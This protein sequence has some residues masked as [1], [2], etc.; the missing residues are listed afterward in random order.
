MRVKNQVICIKT[1][2]PFYHG[3]SQLTSVKV[4]GE[5]ISHHEWVLSGRCLF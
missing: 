2:G 5:Y 3:I 1:F 4:T